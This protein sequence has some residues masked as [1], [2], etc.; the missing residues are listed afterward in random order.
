MTPCRRHEKIRSGRQNWIGSLFF[1]VTEGCK[2]GNVLRFQDFFG[3]NTILTKGVDPALTPKFRS[4][5]ARKAA[6][7]IKLAELDETSCG[8]MNASTRAFH[9][10]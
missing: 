8:P 3:I 2:Y 9:S 4:K 6:Q 10:P 1:C 7:I 5:E